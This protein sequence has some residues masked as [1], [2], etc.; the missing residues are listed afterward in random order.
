MRSLSLTVLCFSVTISGYSKVAYPGSDSTYLISLL[1]KSK[2]N[3]SFNSE[4]VDRE[5]YQYMRTV[6]AHE[7][8][9]IA[10][11]G[12]KFN[13]TDDRLADLCDS[14]IVIYGK[15]KRSR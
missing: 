12:M 14:R 11:R 2:F 7:S 4:K 6:T 8:F 3:I 9:C 13:E 5:F 10:E 15:S 1:I